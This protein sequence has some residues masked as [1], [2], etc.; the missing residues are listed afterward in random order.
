MR[1]AEA[2]RGQSKGISKVTEEVKKSGMEGGSLQLW[3]GLSEHLRDGEHGR[4]SDPRKGALGGNGS[5]CQ[6][7]A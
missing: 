5:K 3:E 4:E 6:R 1:V 7:L 2:Q